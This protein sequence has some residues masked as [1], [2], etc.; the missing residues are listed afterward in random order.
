MENQKIRKNNKN[1]I[2]SRTKGLTSIVLIVLIF[3][4]VLLGISSFVYNKN[5][6]EKPISVSEINVSFMIGDKLGLVTDT[7][8]LKMGRVNRG[9]SATRKF[10]LYPEK[11]PVQVYIKFSDE[12]EEYVFADP[13][14]FIMEPDV[15]NVTVRVTLT[16][17]HNL[18]DGNYSG[19]ATI[20][21]F[22]V[23]K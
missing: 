9:S 11:E 21:Y 17:T 4:I 3:V 12:I 15:D 10:Y 8:M 19:V 16:N 23:D 5:L 2:S 7:D 20:Y 6:S 18:S 1:K 14:N 13:N 22:S